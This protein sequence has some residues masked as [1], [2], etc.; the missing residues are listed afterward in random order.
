MVEWKKQDH[1]TEASHERLN[2][3]SRE[4]LNTSPH[5][6]ELAKGERKALSEAAKF[7]LKVFD[8]IKSSGYNDNI[9]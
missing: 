9:T 5:M 1:F 3:V 2:R 8:I 7:R 6:R 4:F